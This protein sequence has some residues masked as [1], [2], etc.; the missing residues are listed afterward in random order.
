MRFDDTGCYSSVSVTLPLLLIINVPLLFFFLLTP[1]RSAAVNALQHHTISAFFSI[2]VQIGWKKLHLGRL[3][4]INFDVINWRQFISC[5][6]PSSRK[7]GDRIRHRVDGANFWSMCQ[8]LK[9]C[10]VILLLN[11]VQFHIVI[12]IWLYQRYFDV[13]A[14]SSYYSI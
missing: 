11:R 10:L 2:F 9:D 13:P 1:G 12:S 6:M 14:W 8:R 4:L 3:P 5:Q 7:T